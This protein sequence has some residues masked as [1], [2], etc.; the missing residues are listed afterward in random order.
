MATTSSNLT[1]GTAIIGQN[2]N[3]KGS[4]ARA[5][6]LIATAALGLALL[7]G[8][9]FG[10]VQREAQAAATAMR[11]A[12]IPVAAQFVPDQFTY[13]EDHR[14]ASVNPF[15]ADQF[16]YREDHRQ[17]APAV[18]TGT[19]IPDSFTYREDH[20]QVAPAVATG[21]FI[22]DSFTYRE[23]H[24]TVV[25]S[26]FVPDQFTYREDHRASAT[27]AFVPDQFTYREDRRAYP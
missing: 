15:V 21:T 22:P 10:Q 11:S 13:R 6:G 25:T 26:A 7:G 8:L 14:A 16:T 1:A 3:G 20:R 4:K 18:A 9:A 27:T 12:P 19:F 23:D 17:V 24:R 5:A 2:S